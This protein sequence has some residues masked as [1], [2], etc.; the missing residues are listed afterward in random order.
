MLK[1]LGKYTER[2]YLEV[3]IGKTKIMIFRRGGRKSKGEKW[4]LGGRPLE[5]VDSYKCLGFWFLTKNAHR[6][7]VLTLAGKCQKVINT[8]WGL[9]I[10]ARLNT[11]QRR[12]YLMDTIIRAG[13]LYAAEI[14]SWRR[15]EEAERVQSRF[16]KM[17][18]GLKRNTP[19]YI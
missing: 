6:R 4:Y 11:L 9:M 12:L 2:N 14:W 19:S 15:W 13:L 3:N 10:R 17:S 8:T 1:A 16:I 18:M 7:H 5:I